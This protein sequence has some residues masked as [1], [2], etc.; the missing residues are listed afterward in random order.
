MVKDLNQLGKDYM[1]ML[2]MSFLTDNYVDAKTHYMSLKNAVRK[3]AKDGASEDAL[4]TFFKMLLTWI[5]KFE[6]YVTVTLS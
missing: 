6:L 2:I 3:V 5:P 4:N 1:D